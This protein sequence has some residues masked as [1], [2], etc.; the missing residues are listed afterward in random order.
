[1]GRPVEDPY[2]LLGVDRQATT[3]EI[4]AAFRRLA[5][6]THPDR[7]PEDPEAQSRF[8]A[9]NEAQQ[10]LTDPQRRAAYDR[11]GPAAFR[12]GGMGIGFGMA[13]GVGLDGMLG[14]LLGAV[15]I[16]AGGRG[17]IRQRLR[18]TFEEAVLGVTKEITYDRLDTCDRC[19]GAGGERGSGI[20]ACASCAG[21]GRV[22]IST[23][24]IDLPFERPCPTCRGRGQVPRT[25]CTTCAG[26]GVTRRPRTVEVQVP[27]GIESGSSRVVPKA[28]D[29]SHPD[30]QPG[31]LEVVVEV[32]PHPLF[33]RDGDD[34]LCEIPV[35][36]TQA[37]LGGEVEVAT[38]QGRSRL[39]IPPGT[40]PGSRLRMRGMG[41][42]HRLR[43]GRG[44][45]L[46]TVTVTV[47][48]DLTDHARELIEELGRELGDAASAPA[49]ER[50]I[51]RIRR[52]LS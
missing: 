11:Y 41:V 5:A 25:R 10:I 4:K 1:M 34:I 47:P 42:A 26:R 2:Q 36:F 20:Q 27:P 14:D 7:N 17:H 24:I 18:L 16:R 6:Q 50:L 35:T 51:D 13:E 19:A 32:A 38:L 28:G 9:L 23:G 46:V 39:R 3:A 15:G 31:D 8:Q 22:R 49:P 21:R 30:R 12:P 45:Q 29:R 40:Q 48:S 44:D 43:S 52:M 33:R 37:T